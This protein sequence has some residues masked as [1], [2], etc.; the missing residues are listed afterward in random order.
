M[1]R[2]DNGFKRGFV[3]FLCIGVGL[4]MFAFSAFALE[5]RQ[6]TSLRIDGT[7]RLDGV[8]NEDFWEKTTAIRTHDKVAGIEIELSSVQNGESIFFL[9][10]Y[11]DTTE[12]RQH[13]FLVWDETL[14]T[15]KS[16]PKREDSFVFKWNM[17]SRSV[18]LTISG[19]DPYQADV[20]YWK[21]NR[22][23]PVGFA[24][25]KF[26]IYGQNKSVKSLLVISKT[27]KPFYLQRPSDDGK[28]AYSSMAYD[29]YSSPEVPRYKNRRPMGSRAD[30]RAK[31]N[32]KN[33]VWTIEWARKLKTGHTD[34]VQFESGLIYS[35]GVSRFEIAGKSA[36]PEI[37][38]P[39][40]ERG[41]ITERLQLKIE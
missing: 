29:V 24:D 5:D 22:T 34:D 20:W 18:D 36:N 1:R 21:A 31:G 4:S 10:R 27:G 23:D 16:G 28:S 32:W 14:K 2:F 7:P 39:N 6:M 8:A 25:D 9:V 33:G 30:I 40:Y 13:K 38:Q 11:P 26:H 37:D 15:Y 3:L 35:F 12:S 19:N 17:G 41:E